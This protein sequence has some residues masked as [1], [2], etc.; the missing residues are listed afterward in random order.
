MKI[1]W[2]TKLA[3]AMAA[4]MIMII[5]FV[6]LMMREDVNLV[7]PDYYP[8]GQKF[9][10]IIDMKQKSATLSDS[11]IVGYN[12]GFIS[13]RFPSG[14]DYSKISG[15]VHFYHRVESK[16]DFILDLKV[17]TDGVLRY[18]ADNLQGRFIVKTEWKNEGAN[19]F[20]ENVLN[21]Q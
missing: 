12:E 17:G 7:E 19:Y 14:L 3:I 20:N 10:E 8:K 11:L 16:M 21:L 1:N 18:K 5:T 15:S 4:F 13:I 9:Q 2:G 6:V